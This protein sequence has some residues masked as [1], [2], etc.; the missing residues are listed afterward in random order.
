MEIMKDGRLVAS[1]KRQGGGRTGLPVTWLVYWGLAYS[2]NPHRRFA[3][4]QA[5]AAWVKSLVFQDRLA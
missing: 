2:G 3:R 5:A 4:R 1:L